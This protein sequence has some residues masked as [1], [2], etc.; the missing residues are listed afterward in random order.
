MSSIYNQ[1]DLY[2]LYNEKKDSIKAY[3]GELYGEINSSL[4]GSSGDLDKIEPKIRKHIENIDSFMKEGEKDKYLVLYR[5]IYNLRNFLRFNNSIDSS[6]RIIDLAFSSATKNIKVTRSFVDMNGCCVLAFVLSSEI[7]RYVYGDELAEDEV[8]LQRNLQF[9]LESDQPII[10]SSNKI[11][12][13]K[14]IVK[15]YDPPKIT[16]KDFDMLEKLEH[17]IEEKLNI[18]EIGDIEEIYQELKELSFDS[19]ITEEDIDIYIE[20]NKHWSESKKKRIK[21]KLLEMIKN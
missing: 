14:A 8:L 4:R 16:K 10:D 6:P 2:N 20:D 21:D 3:K 7:K 18:G 9:I 19:N 13:Y 17:E 12:I 1:S 11:Q 15:P 5:G